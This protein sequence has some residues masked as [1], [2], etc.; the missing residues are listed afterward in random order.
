[1]CRIIKVPHRHLKV[2][3]IQPNTDTLVECPIIFMTVNTLHC[4]EKCWKY[5]LG[6]QHNKKTHK[7][8]EILC[9]Y[10]KGLNSLVT[11]SSHKVPESTS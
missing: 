7:M 1:M 3:Q 11:K 5:F 6:S 8:E 2:W 10:G 4:I 9:G